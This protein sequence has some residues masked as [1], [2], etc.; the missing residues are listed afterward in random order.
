MCL[1]ISKT[2]KNV[3]PHLPSDKILDFKD[4]DMVVIIG[5]DDP[6]S[7]SDDLDSDTYEERELR[8]HY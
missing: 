6:V 3:L 4:L 5:A 1:V 8:W 7:S 2:R